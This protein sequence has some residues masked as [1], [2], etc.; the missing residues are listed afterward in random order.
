MPCYRA[1]SDHV[2]EAIS[3]PGIGASWTTFW[4]EVPCCTPPT[5]NAESP[6]SS[7]PVLCTD[8]EA[9]FTGIAVTFE[10]T[11]GNFV[12][13]ILKAASVSH[14]LASD[15]DL[16]IHVNC[17]GNQHPD[18]FT[19][20]DDSNTGYS[21]SNHQ[22]AANGTLG[23]D[24]WHGMNFTVAELLAGIDLNAEDSVNAPAY[25]SS[26]VSQSLPYRG[27]WTMRIIAFDSSLCLSGSAYACFT[28]P[29]MSPDGGDTF[30]PTM[31]SCHSLYTDGSGTF[32]QFNTSN[33]GTVTTATGTTYDNVIQV[34]ANVDYYTDSLSMGD[35]SFSATAFKIEI[36]YDTS[37]NSYGGCGSYSWANG[38]D[39]DTY[40]AAGDGGATNEQTFNVVEA[41]CWNE[42]YIFVR[43][44]IVAQ[45]SCSGGT[46]NGDWTA[47]YLG[48][49]DVGGGGVQCMSGP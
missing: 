25:D 29:P 44:R 40:L 35:D 33:S 49:F 34:M 14:A 1:K 47:G 21:C 9:V 7:D 38:I 30:Y 26:P 16:T 20:A 2:S 41:D 42:D 18:G 6:P 36:Q 19:G 46:I 23:I 3:K 4:V 28:V 43:Y 11:S 27:F 22:S 15:S 48:E 8:P 13:P 32:P 10:I 24:L 45:S 5:T 39:N 37:C 12:K 17:Y 31:P